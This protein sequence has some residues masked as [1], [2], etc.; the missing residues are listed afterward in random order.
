M[1]ED[2]FLLLVVRN[3]FETMRVFEKGRKLLVKCIKEIEEEAKLYVAVVFCFCGF[4]SSTRFF[5]FTEL[6]FIFTFL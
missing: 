5:F 3:Y 2:R 4:F 6:Y 1:L